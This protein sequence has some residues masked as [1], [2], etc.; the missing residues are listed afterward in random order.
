MEEMGGDRATR[1]IPTY[2]GSTRRAERGRIVFSNHSHVCGINITKLI[3]TFET[4]ESFPRM[5]DQR[6]D[7]KT[8]RCVLR[9]IPTYV[10]STSSARLIQWQSSNHSHVCGINAICE[11]TFLR[12]HRIIPTYV[13]STRISFFMLSCCFESFPRM[14]DQHYACIEQGT[15]NPNHSHVCGINVTPKLPKDLCYESF[16]RMWDQRVRARS[17]VL[18][19]ANH[20]HVCGINPSNVSP[21]AVLDESFP[22]M[23]DQLVPPGVISERT[24]I[25]PTYVGSTCHAAFIASV[26]P[27]HSHVCGINLSLSKI[28]IFYPRIIPT[29]VGSTD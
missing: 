13:G 11:F 26:E 1:I 19:M 18:R 7:R 2:V 24:R 15:H 10:G 3:S 20:S 29:Y 27:N 12:R 23:W 17:V 9:I 8:F 4:Y 14:W 16:P 6:D 28:L 21:S 5:W 22:R 25:I